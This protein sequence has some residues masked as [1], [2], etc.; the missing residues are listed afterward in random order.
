MIGLENY[1]FLTPE[2]K[3]Q[4]PNVYADVKNQSMKGFSNT[5]EEGTS[6]RTN[7]LLAKSYRVVVVFTTDLPY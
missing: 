6:Q 4:R 7:G 5:P 3:M 2:F 1:T